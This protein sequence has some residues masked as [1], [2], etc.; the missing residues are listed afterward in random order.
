MVPSNSLK[1]TGSAVVSGLA[2][3][4]V[5]KS[6]VVVVCCVV[7]VVIRSGTVVVSVALVGV[8]LWV[9]TFS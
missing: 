7:F 5:V 6:G 3:G 8:K 2:E 9:V 1:V 4:L